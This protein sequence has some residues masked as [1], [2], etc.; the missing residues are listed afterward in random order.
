MAT[1]VQELF[2][3]I[4]DIPEEERMKMPIVDLDS[5]LYYAE[6]VCGALMKEL[7]DDNGKY[8]CPVFSDTKIEEP[9][10]ALN[11]YKNRVHYNP[12]KPVTA[13]RIVDKHPYEKIS[14]EHNI[15]FRL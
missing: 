14:R 12:M 5:E 11:K 15:S 7:L 1:N 4:K 8:S 10:D 13:L 3:L 2:E 9:E 6:L